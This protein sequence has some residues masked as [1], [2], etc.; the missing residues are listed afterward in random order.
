[1]A[2]V[3]CS[4]VYFAN[5]AFDH[6]GKVL[7]EGRKMA[8]REGSAYEFFTKH[9]LV[10]SVATIDGAPVPEEIAVKL[11]TD[12]QM[13]PPPA[14]GKG[15]YQKTGEIPLDVVGKTERSRAR[16]RLLAKKKK[17]AAAAAGSHE[18]DFV[19]DPAAEKAAFHREVMAALNAGAPGL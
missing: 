8:L 13:P 5:R 16:G 1:M 17:E 12:V 6:I 14:A 3:T 11:C 19:F 10:V 4:K 7:Q 15:K 18:R 9:G 2:S